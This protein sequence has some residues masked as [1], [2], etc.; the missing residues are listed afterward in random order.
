MSGQGQK[1]SRSDRIRPY[2]LFY[3]KNRVVPHSCFNASVL[4][5]TASKPY[6]S[7]DG[8]HKRVSFGSFI[9]SDIY[10]LGVEWSSGVTEPGS[11]G[12][13]LLNTDRQIIGQL[14]GGWDGPGSSCTNP[15]APDQYGRFDVTYPY[16][17][18][19]IDPSGS[20]A[21]PAPVAGTFYG[22][23]YDQSTGVIPGSSGS[24]TD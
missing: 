13:P 9:R 23:F 3:P 10:Y 24:L 11:S 15:T 21:G 18:K 2:G 1:I 7:P 14:T 4:S 16:I 19:W 20:F 5:R 12:S 22:L 8:S 6:F 17:R